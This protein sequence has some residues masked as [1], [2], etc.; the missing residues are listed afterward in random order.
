MMQRDPKGITAYYWRGRCYSAQKEDPAVAEKA[1]PYYEQYVAFAIKDKAKNK[2][3]L[4]VSLR[5]LGENYLNQKN[6][7]C[8]KACYEL[9]KELEPEDAAANTA[10]QDKQISAATAADITTCFAQP[11]LYQ[12]PAEQ[13]KQEGNGQ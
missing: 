1:R 11:M 8:A 10:L 5:W 12:P 7:S 2:K 3:D 13:P 6:Y 4:L 9:I